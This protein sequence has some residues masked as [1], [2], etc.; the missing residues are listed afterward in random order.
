MQQYTK[1]DLNR[2]IWVK[3]ELLEKQ[4]K[5]YQIDAAGKVL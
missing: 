3:P 2:T 5:W 1:Q 4:R